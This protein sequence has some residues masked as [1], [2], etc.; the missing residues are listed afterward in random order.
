M[1]KQ[2]RL[3]L[4]GGG[5]AHVY[6]LSKFYSE[7]IP[8]THIMLVSASKYQYYSGMAAGY[9][10]GIYR[11]DE[12]C[13]DLE[14]LCQRSG[15][16]FIESRVLGLNPENRFVEL[17]NH[18]KVY[19]D[20]LSLDTGSEM[21]GKSIEGVSE[22]AYSVKPLDN[23]LN[24]R[25]NFLEQHFNG[26]H[27][28]IAGAGAAGI[29]MS[30]SLKSLSKKMK[31]DA[32]ITLLDGGDSILKGYSEGVKKKL[33]KKLEEE[34]IEVLTKHRI[35]KIKAGLV[36]LDSG[37]TISYDFLV[38]AVGPAS[39][40]M[41]KASGL[42]VDQ[43]GY[44]IVNRCLQSVDYPYIFGAGDCIAF[45]EFGYV[46]KVGVYAIREAPYLYNNILGFLKK[47]RLHEYIPQKDYLAIIATGSRT[48]V[49]Q[50][51]GISMRG[52]ISWVIKNFIDNRFMKRFRK[53]IDSWLK[54]L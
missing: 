42:T 18:E 35:A 44:M 39:N 37:S 49:M 17:H 33:Q 41:Y 54:Q 19:F 16:D 25:H 45:S 12:I 46:K 34:G 38:W 47:T 31:K 43:A 52:H 22:Y 2:R 20:I 28:L 32:R 10:E 13:F 1:E 26:A 29:E 24:L 11:E 3:L 6:L 15:I 40:P 7:K 9:V 23:L 51:K 48:G 50:Y 5:H 21:A 27:T 53:H 36:E 4:V 8:D 30:L 14:K